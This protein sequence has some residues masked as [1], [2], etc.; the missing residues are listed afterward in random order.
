MCTDYSLPGSNFISKNNISDKQNQ[1][2]KKTTRMLVLS[3]GKLVQLLHMLILQQLPENHCYPHLYNVL[4][5]DYMIMLG[6]LQWSWP[7]KWYEFFSLKHTCVYRDPISSYTQMQK[8]RTRLYLA[9]RQV[10]KTYSNY[11]SLPQSNGCNSGLQVITRV[12]TK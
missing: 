10:L 8:Q 4:Q 3:W 11:S 6:K 9:C 7:K 5:T 2:V 1:G 12:Y